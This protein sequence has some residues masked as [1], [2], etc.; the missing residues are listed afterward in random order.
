MS[1][2]RL[3]WYSHCHRKAL[4]LPQINPWNL[5][6][7]AGAIH[8]ALTMDEEERRARH[9]Y[10]FNYIHIHTAQK[11]A[12]TFI[13]T[14]KEACAESE[15]ITARVPP[16]L[17]YIIFRTARVGM[18]KVNASFTIC[19]TRDSSHLNLNADGSIRMI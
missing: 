6:E 12:E 14:L 10:A 4:E 15:E 13:H 9:E 7:T 8:Q 1:A 16:L 11:W 19:P 3:S 5:Q 17:P 2:R 18:S